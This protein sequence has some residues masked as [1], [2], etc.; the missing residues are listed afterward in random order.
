R[1]VRG[2]IRLFETEPR[3]EFHFALRKLPLIAPEAI[4]IAFPFSSPDSE[5]VY[6]GQGGLVHPGAGQIPGSASDWQTVQ[7]FAVIRG[8][9]GQIILGSD[10]V[11]L[12]QLGDLN[13]GKWQPITTISK[14]HVYSWVMNNY[15]FTNFRATQ[16]GEFKWSYYLTS[17]R[18]TGN[19]AATQFGWGSRIPLIAR[20]LAPGNTGDRPAIL[21]ALDL[22][23]PNLALVS[24]RPAHY[25]K[26]V[27][28]HLRE[29]EGRATT[30]PAATL[31]GAP[32][33]ASVEEVN[34]L[35]ECV[36]AAPESISFAPFEPRFVRILLK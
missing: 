26:G 33:A 28:L 12:V 3:I 20:V 27:V 2:E 24:A 35:E 25:G 10:A 7:G 9:D 15:W 16:E 34:P 36:N 5:I 17:T 8:G 18:D 13:L 11:P 32:G 4:Y 19:T 6:E 22:G 1:G 21:S 29:L 14:P 31:L 30:L 23:L